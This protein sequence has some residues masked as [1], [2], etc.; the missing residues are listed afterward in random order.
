V[1]ICYFGTYDQQYARNQILINGLRANGVTV[2]E[3]HETLWQDGT[4]EK[5]A[6]AKGGWRSPAFLW[7]VLCIYARLARRFLA[8]PRDYDVI[9][10]GYTGQFDIYLARWLAWWVRKPLV[11]DVLISVYQETIER[12]LDRVSPL[13]AR[14]LYAVEWLALRLADYLLLDTPEHAKHLGQLYGLSPARF[15]WVPLG[16]DDRFYEP[17]PAPAR[18]N[19]FHVVYY[20]S[21]IPLHG[22]DVIVEAANQLRDQP[23]I[24]FDLVGEGQERASAE[25]RVAELGLTNVTFYGWISKEFIAAEI[26]KTDVVL[27]MFGTT[28]QSTCQLQNKIYEGMAMA[29]PVI[30]GRVPAITH[31]VIAHGQHVWMCEPNNPT[32]LADAVLTL[33]RDPALRTRL[34]EQGHQLYLQAFT[35]AHVARRLIN[36]LEG[37]LG[38]MPAAAS[39]V[40]EQA[41]A[42]E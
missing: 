35:P 36:Y 39:A 13:T 22:V 6:R 29:K 4:W 21:F 28:R 17:L 38:T 9:V 42:S 3:C 34:A 15:W 16:A 2:T 32:A 10:L 31:S 26:A 23:D 5:I 24:V 37:A 1:H 25:A 7:R 40:C 41:R 12:G 20:G 30:T 33:Y 11:L 27:G 8:L 18:D 14:L 19:R